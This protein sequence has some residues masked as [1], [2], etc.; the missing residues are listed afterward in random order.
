M[1]RLLLHVLFLVLATFGAVLS[2]GSL[3]RETYRWHGLEIELRL[4]P[5]RYGDT[6][7][8][9]K[10]LGEIHAKTHH[11]PVRLIASL[12]R[13]EVDELKKL[14]TVKTDPTKLEEEFKT[15]AEATLRAFVIRQLAFAAL[16]A[17]LAPLLFRSLRFR[18]YL[19]AAVLGAAIVGGALGNAVSTFDR[20]AFSNVTYTGALKQ[21]P[22][23]I[24][25][26]RDAFT[27]FDALSSKLRLVADNLNVLYGRIAAVQDNVGESGETTFRVLHISDIHNNTAAFDFVRKVADQFKV[28][29]I[30]DTGDLTDFGSPPE[31]VIINKIGKLPYRYVFVAGNHDSKAVTDALT[32]LSN[33][34]VLNGQTLLVGDLRFL[35]LPNPAS[36]RDGAGN[37]DPDPAGTSANATQLLKIFDLSPENLRPD[38]V[39]THDPRETVPLWGKV[40]VAL[41]GHLHRQY[42]ERQQPA[43]SQRPTVV[44]NAGTT[45]AAGL[46]YFEGHGGKEAFTCSVLTFLKR[47][48]TNPSA[49][50]AVSPRPKLLAIDLIQ[51]DGGLNQYSISHQTL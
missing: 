44:S 40:P 20:Q 9:L 48:I 23:V 3:G 39:V 29:L 30:V 1:R 7:L 42:V 22:W 31:L 43:N 11:A 34:S 32:K 4:L 25:F 38:I 46:R 37:V 5:V 16:G 45:G 8:V 17:L 47:T 6:E 26:G 24:Q 27:K 10:P 49:S 18:H 21:A 36:L 13:I 41:V 2:V 19:V 50:G 15:T 33:V 12:E 14:V 51:L 35:G 28:A